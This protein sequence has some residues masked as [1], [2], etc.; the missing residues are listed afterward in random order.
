MLNPL[1]R[2]LRLRAA[3]GA[4]AAGLHRRRAPARPGHA[5]R[6][7]QDWRHYSLI[8]FATERG[9]TDAPRRVP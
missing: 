9:A 2:T 6:R 5:A 7:Q 1:I 4:R 8:N 3:D